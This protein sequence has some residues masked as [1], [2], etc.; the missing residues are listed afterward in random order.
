MC[1]PATLTAEQL[2][3]AALGF[4]GAYEPTRIDRTE[5]TS[6]L[7]AILTPITHDGLRREDVACLITAANDNFR[8]WECANNPM[9]DD[10]AG[11]LRKA[12]KDRR[13]VEVVAASICDGGRPE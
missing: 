3:A 2:T 8:A 6:I 12:E 13:R 7:H 9:D 4:V 11:W 10:R 1:K 5:L